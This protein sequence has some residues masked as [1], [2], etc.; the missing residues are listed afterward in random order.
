MNSITLTAS[1]TRPADTTAYAAN[2]ALSDSTSAP[3]YLTFGSVTGA[4]GP[5]TGWLV[6]AR[7]YSSANQSTLPQLRLFLYKSVP[8][9]V[10]DNAALTMTDAQ[11][12]TCVAT[13]TFNSFVGGD[14]TAGAG[15]NAFCTASIPEPVAVSA[16]L[17]GLVKVLNAYTPVSAEVVTFDLD[18]AE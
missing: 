4:A 18:I 15:G 10:N 13:L 14:D 11:L 2:E 3:T 12:L 16:P 9:A 1:Y 8:T 17:F 7:C 5:K 6:G